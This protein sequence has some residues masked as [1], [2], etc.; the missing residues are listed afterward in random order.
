[1][2]GKFRVLTSPSLLRDL[3]K[4]RLST[5]RDVKALRDKVGI[6]HNARSECVREATPIK[7]QST[8]SDTATHL[9]LPLCTVVPRRNPDFIGRE[10]QLAEL[11]TC[12]LHN[13][14]PSA[15]TLYA[16]E[17]IGGVG[18]T[19]LALEFMY[20]YKDFYHAIFWVGAESD[21]EL[22]STYGAIGR[23]LKLFDTEC[24]DQTKIEKV[25]DWLANNG[26]Y[27]KVIVVV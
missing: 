9:R 3:K 2:T 27:V 19:Q 8:P 6:V 26:A 22:R 15:P 21:S 10:R 20:R 24:I 11:Y 23:S 13:E 12:L 7:P 16:V 18:K 14:E 5:S 1:M 25:Q 17:G 4:I